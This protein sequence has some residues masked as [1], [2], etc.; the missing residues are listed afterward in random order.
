M[1][2]SASAGQNRSRQVKR[3]YYSG[4]STI[5]EGMAVCYDYDSTTDIYTG[6]TVSEGSQCNG[7]F[8]YVEDPTDNNIDF[9]AGVV[10]GQDNVGKSGPAWIN[11]YVANGSIVPVRTD[12]SVAKGDTRLFVEGSDS[13]LGGL[14][15]EVGNAVRCVGIAEETVD[16]SGTA[17]LTLA[18]LFMPD[19]KEVYD[20]SSASGR[21]P[22]E[23]LWQDCPLEH[24]KNEPGYGYAHFN[25]YMGETIAPGTS[26]DAD[27][28][29]IT[30]STT[31]SIG[32]VIGVGG[33]L[34]AA[35]GGST[36]DQGINAQLLNACVK[37]AANK[38]IWFEARVKVSHIDNQ[39]FVGVAET[40]T[41]LISSGALDDGQSDGSMIGFFT[42]DNATTG[43][44]G[45][46]TGKNGTSDQEDGSATFSATTFYK[47]GFRV[48]GV[49]SVQFYVDGTLNRTVSDTNDI[50]DGVEMALSYVCQNEDGANS[51]T[52]NVDWVQMAQLA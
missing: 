47:L 5:Y 36:Q 37:P 50:A 45:T 43:K 4:N 1:T 40:N 33:Q 34:Q 52:M 17:G 49:S 22:S 14:G 23:D 10:A 2:M 42:D 39:V 11:I 51:N 18:R 38:T 46:V 28:W 12:V 32:S 44:I 31:G 8:S 3:A 27:G 19:E 13:E 9:F 21:G 7:K 29:T 35:A 16:R 41:G 24:I 26:A 20:V 30:Q 15:D 25:D 48:N 6:E